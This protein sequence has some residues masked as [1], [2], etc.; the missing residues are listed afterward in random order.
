MKFTGKW[1]ELEN[2]ILSEVKEE[3]TW[4]TLTDKWLLAQKFGIPK[5]QFTDHMKPK[6]K[7]DQNVDASLHP[8][9]THRRKYGDKVWSRD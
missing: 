6:K 9:N 2:I 1:M 7:E 5:I 3:H 4:C 8:Q